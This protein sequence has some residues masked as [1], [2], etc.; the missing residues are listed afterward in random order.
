MSIHNEKK[1]SGIRSNRS[2][3]ESSAKK[4]PIGPS[5]QKF[6][7]P[8]QT[9]APGL[10]P[11]GRGIIPLPTPPLPYHQLTFN[12]IFSLLFIHFNP[13][14]R[15]QPPPLPTFIHPTPPVVFPNPQCINPSPST[16]LN[17]PSTYNYSNPSF[18]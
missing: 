16:M 18:L 9:V 1:M 8:G 12:P 4:S 2:T 11:N 14:F 17:K 15:A 3:E 7:L 10:I 13:F 5:I 6:Y